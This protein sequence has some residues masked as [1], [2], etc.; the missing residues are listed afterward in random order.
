VAAAPPPAPPPAPNERQLLNEA[1]AALALKQLDRAGIKYTSV[2]DIEPTNLVALSSL[3]AIRY[4][5]NRYDE[6]ED[7]LRKAVAEAP[8]DAETRSL[9]G[10]VFY[11]KGLTEDSFNELT[12]AVALD[13]HNAEAHNYLGIVLSQ[14]GWGAAGEQEIRRAI[15][16]NPQYADA[17]FNLAVV[18][19]KQ[20]T[21]NVELAKYHYKKAL[22]LGAPADPQLEALLKKL[23]EAPPSADPGDTTK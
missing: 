13:P 9:L 5:Q 4:Q 8:N 17:H 14:K 15:E 20:R 16:I 3:G 12:R 10:V 19:A 6:A 1:R 18:Y 7:Y 21:P 23:S 2:L 11:R 22:D